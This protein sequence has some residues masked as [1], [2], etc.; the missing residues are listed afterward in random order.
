MPD[1]NGKK[2]YT[3]IASLSH[4]SKDARYETYHYFKERNA[5]IQTILANVDSIFE[6]A[7]VQQ[8]EQQPRAKKRNYDMSL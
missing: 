2:F 5:E 3:S 8:R 1:R 6:T 4:T 7:K